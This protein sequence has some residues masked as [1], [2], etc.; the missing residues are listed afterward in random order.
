MITSAM[1]LYEMIQK[2]TICST[3]HIFLLLASWLKNEL[4]FEIQTT[5][6]HK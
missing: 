1:G 3:L 4:P 6:T 5:V 2:T